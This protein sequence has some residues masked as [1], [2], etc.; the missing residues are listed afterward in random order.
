MG[1]QSVNELLGKTDL[2]LCPP[3]TGRGYYADERRIVA[4]GHP[5]IDKEEYVVGKDG[6]KTWILTTK[7]PVRAPDAKI[8]GIAGV[9]RDI[10][11]RRRADVLRKGQ[12]QILEKIALG[13]PLEGVLDSLIRLI[14]TQIFRCRRHASACR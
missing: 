7:V 9:S 10:S 12:A 14:G 2:E 4:T 13:A 3:E 6:E 8:F 11:D 1:L 5:M